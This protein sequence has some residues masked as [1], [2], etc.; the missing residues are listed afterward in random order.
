MWYNTFDLFVSVL[1]GNYAAHLAEAKA[2]EGHQNLLLVTY[3]DLKNNNLGE[4]EKIN[5]FIG[6]NLNKQQLN[7]V[8]FFTIVLIAN[9]N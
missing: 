3:E 2:K 8:S 9:A 1:Y 7:N 5:K 6:A 4:L